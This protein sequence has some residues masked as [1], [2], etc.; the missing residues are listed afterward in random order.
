MEDSMKKQA[1]AKPTASDP[2]ALETLISMV[3]ESEE[4]TANSRELAERDRDYYDN[5]QWTKEEKVALDARGQPVV[6]SNRIKRKIEYLE[7]AETLQRTDPKAFPRNPGDE[8]AAEAATDS[9]RFVCDNN[10]YDVIRSKIW[11]NLLIEGFGGAEVVVK[12]VGER[13]EISI[14]S[15]SWDR[16]FYDPHSSEPDFSD[17]KYKGVILWMDYAAAL[18]KWPE[19]KEALDAT[20]DSAGPADTYDDKPKHL[21]W[22]DGKRKRVRIVYIWYLK[23]KDWNWC[24]FSKGGKIKGGKSPYLNEDNETVCPLEMTSAYVDRDNNRYGRAREMIS[25]QDEINKRRS[26][27]LHLLSVRQVIAEEGAV[28]SETEAK[29]ELAKPDGWVTKAPGTKLEIVQNGDMT[30]GHFSLLQDAKNEIDHNGP[31]DAQMGKVASSAS[32]RAIQ[33]S[34]QGGQVDM[35]KLNDRR[36]Q[37][38]K[39]VYQQ[40]WWRIR[41]FWNEERW[42]R[43]TDDERN[44]RFVGLNRP[45]TAGEKY[46]EQ[47]R[48][49]GAKEE[50]IAQEEQR[51]STLPNAQQIVGM[52]NETGKMKVDILIED[53]PD[54]VTIQQE[55]FD[56][57]VDLAKVGAPIPPDAL[58]EASSLRNKKIILE[59]MRGDPVRQQE[60]E[61]IRKTGVELDFGKKEADIQKTLAQAAKTESEIKEPPPDEIILVDEPIEG[62]PRI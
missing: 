17:G 8:M 35:A 49:S 34:Q 47:L 40:I 50:E 41:Q 20:L 53:A 58:I 2:F 45:V 24:F 25:P 33:A 22:T 15:Y 12:P 16:L 37:W 59:K 44:V 7:G 4:A 43:V 60:E 36:R 1:D 27:S 48:E 3:E 13:L 5:K 19:A 28:D 51:I 61:E 14:N 21:L 46:L 39:K 29:R 54:T 11:S 42:I 52:N 55:Q 6:T 32:G 30:Q 57:L 62:I 26:K 38:D 56:K 31:N 23:S 18:D 9:I 10:E